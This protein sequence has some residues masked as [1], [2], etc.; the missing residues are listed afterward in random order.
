MQRFENMSYDEIRS[1]VQV[2][3]E[4]DFERMHGS[5]QKDHYCNR[6]DLQKVEQGLMSRLFRKRT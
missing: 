6:N 3:V 1:H 5:L 2:A 4:E